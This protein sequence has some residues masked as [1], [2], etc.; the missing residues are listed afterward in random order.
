MTA[1]LRNFNV[2]AI[3]IAATFCASANHTFAADVP[4]ASKADSPATEA[5][6]ADFES[7][8]RRAADHFTTG[9][10]SEA[11]TD[12]RTL[13]DDAKAKAEDATASLLTEQSY[14]YLGESLV[15]LHRPTE[16]IEAF[17]SFLASSKDEGLVPIARYRLGEACYSKS[18]F[19]EARVAFAALLDD[20]EKSGRWPATTSRSLYYLGDLALRKGNFA[21][22]AAWFGHLTA[23]Y[24]DDELYEAAAL[25]RSEALV[26]V[27]E[28]ATAW[29]AL[30]ADYEAE[31]PTP[32]ASFLAAQIL[33][34]ESNFAGVV[35][36]YDRYLAAAPSDDARRDVV[37]Y[38]SAWY[39]Q[40]LNRPKEAAERFAEVLKSHPQS[41]LAAD[42]AYR[43]AEY[44]L[45][46]GRHAEATKLLTAARS[47]AKRD[48]L[49]HVL[50]LEIQVAISAGDRAAGEAAAEALE[51]KLSDHPAALNAPYWKAE[52]A[53]RAGDWD[54][55]A[56]RFTVA[57]AKAKE[58]KLVWLPSAVSRQ[59]ES[60]AQAGRWA[61][62]IAAVEQSRTLLPK[63]SPRFELDYLGGRAHAARA[64][65]RE[66][67][68]A[69]KL[70]LTD[71][72]SKGTETAALAQFM[73]AETY[74]HQRDYA[75]AL[76]DYA[77]V[78]AQSAFAEWRAAAL[79][80]SGKCQEQL[81]RSAEAKQNYERL[82]TEF[83]DSPYA[84]D[85]ARRRDA[86][87]RQA[88]AP[89]GN[90]QRK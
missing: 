8:Y 9:R 35:E 13:I 47:S 24:P 58:R 74:F 26:S 65:F 12:F 78:A 17:G 90:V 83:A 5:S 25:S 71:A 4:D 67:R 15:R 73:T 37:L 33:E 56:D 63:E 55:A 61:E 44:E 29:A 86:A 79:L 82:I 66:A 85:A 52:I 6:V 60:L 14:F 75:A 27:G 70:V 18:R 76:A 28:R 72:R 84:A 62:T 21:E 49:P 68:D 32:R 41:A 45:G 88:E 30:R 53:Y 1:Q 54:A 22:A 77:P 69:Y 51:S 3:L 40:K 2:A 59:I 19:D 7:R 23:V 50:A 57:V 34:A 46:V 39:L 16:A 43:A 11:A 48:L 81:G 87:L 38:E 64:E 80:Q 31:K 20:A 10:W 89:A 42:A 36:A